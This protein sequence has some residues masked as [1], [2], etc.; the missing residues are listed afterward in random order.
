MREERK[1]APEPSHRAA[2]RAGA[3]RPRRRSREE[4]S[5]EAVAAGP[6]PT[7]AQ[8]P[9]PT[10]GA[11]PGGDALAGAAHPGQARPG[12]PLPDALQLSPTAQPA[13]ALP[14]FPPPGTAGASSAAQAAG[15]LRGATPAPASSTPGVTPAAPA[16]SPSAP[17]RG[18]AARPAQQAAP[19]P[20]PQRAAEV[21][22]QIRVHVASSGRA[23]S[24]QLAPDELGR[25]SI[26]LALED[27]TVSAVVRAESKETL[28]LLEQHLPELRAAL[29][30][31]GLEAEHFD[32][33]LGLGG[34]EAGNDHPTPDGAGTPP[35]AIQEN[36]GPEMRRLER[37]LERRLV[38]ETGVDTW[39]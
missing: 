29:A 5:R 30:A 14:T 13:G 16:T 9:A 27:G 11:R 3:D 37:A 6:A 18:A 10:G 25:I 15:A 4:M 32:L 35:S 19:T 24:L 28:A 17:Q 33:G 23:A 20:E 26:R 2:E 34:R 31:S 21:L 8:A 36:Q 1:R 22:E 39:A 7:S 38:S 12:A